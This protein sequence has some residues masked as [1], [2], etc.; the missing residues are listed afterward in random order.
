MRR[1]TAKPS[2]TNSSAP[3]A[4]ESPKTTPKINVETTEMVIVDEAMRGNM[5]MLK[6]ILVDYVSI[7]VKRLVANTLKHGVWLVFD[8]IDA[9]NMHFT[10]KRMHI[11]FFHLALIPNTNI[12][13]KQDFQTA[14]DAV[15]KVLAAEMNEVLVGLANLDKCTSTKG[16]V[17]NCGRT[18]I[19]T[20]KYFTV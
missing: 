8:G 1:R 15:A 7:K 9:L 19:S 10:N 5:I 2:K 12:N 4:A 11:H 14:S 16:I 17:A 20:E 3:P 13:N 6:K 18:I